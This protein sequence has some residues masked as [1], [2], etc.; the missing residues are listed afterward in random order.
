MNSMQRI[1]TITGTQDYVL[2]GY[3]GSISHGLYTPNSI[4]DK[5]VMGIVIPSLSYYF[6]LKSFGN[7]G[8]KEIKK[9][10]WDIVIYEIRKFVSLLKKSNPNVLSLLWLEKNDY[11][12]V[13][14]AG[15][16]LIENRDM[17]LSKRV[18]HSYCG[19]AYS[20]LHRMTHSACS[21]YMGEK[22]KQLVKKFGYDTK[23]ASHLIRLLKMGIETLTEGK[24]YVKRRSD[25]SML[26]EIKR[27][28][29]SLEEVK[30]YAGNLFE[31]IEYSYIHSKL[32]N[33]VNS[34]KVD[35]LLVYILSKRTYEN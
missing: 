26:L 12:Y 27:G 15:R 2:V 4:D 22:R 7:K 13:G 30:R 17:F 16:I 9:D 3:R 11:I 10:E 20:Q 23:N 14:E 32:P 34:E 28:E 19:Y 18:Y 5:D 8:T 6:G 33:E 31:K 21:G 35:E 29:W 1:Q 25:A 24:L